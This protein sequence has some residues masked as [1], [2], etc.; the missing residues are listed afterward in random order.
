MVLLIFLKVSSVDILSICSRCFFNDS[1]R[2][3]SL[4]STP[5]LANYLASLT[6]ASKYTEL[7]D[8]GSLCRRSVH[9]TRWDSLLTSVL[10]CADGK[11]CESRRILGTKLFRLFRQNFRISAASAP[12]SLLCLDS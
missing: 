12:S 5:L 10:S 7:I 2:A 3:F 4:P 11:D 9:S 1:S 8:S 6:S